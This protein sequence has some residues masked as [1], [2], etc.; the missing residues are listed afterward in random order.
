MPYYPSI[1][2]EQL[3]LIEAT[4]VFFIASVD[5]SQAPGPHGIG[6]VNL[7]PKGGVP[8]IVVDRNRVAYLDY[9]GS[10][11]ETAR[12]S[13]AGGATTIMICSFEETDPV[14][15][16]LYGKVRVTSIVDSPLAE[17]LLASPA[18]D[19]KAPRQVVELVI[20][21]TQ[22]SCGYGVPILKHVRDRTKAERGRRY[23]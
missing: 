5:P 18:A 21:S 13:E 17:R 15:V 4:P 12:H 20:E 2:D 22:T 23:K 6:P 19:L 3:A 7:S 9:P 10:G 11:N 8:L 16:R 1:T 14:I